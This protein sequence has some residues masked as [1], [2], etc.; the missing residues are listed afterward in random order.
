MG[1]YF[2]SIGSM[3]D[4]FSVSVSSTVSTVIQEA[5]VNLGFAEGTEKTTRDMTIT[6]TAGTNLGQF[7][8]KHN[9]V[10][11]QVVVNPF[12]IDTKMEV[13]QKTK[14]ET[15]ATVMGMDLKISSSGKLNTGTGDLSKTSE[16]S[17]GK[18]G[19][20]VYASTKSDSKGSSGNVGVQ[21]TGTST[22]SDGKTT[23]SMNIR[24]NLL[25]FDEKKK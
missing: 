1:T 3:V 25:L 16:V 21:A 7:F 2:Q 18:A 4:R 10:N 5:K 17:L 20:G 11:N 6:T 22:D 13:S 24:F 9:A 19:M 15:K 23:R 14:I 8:D 12:K